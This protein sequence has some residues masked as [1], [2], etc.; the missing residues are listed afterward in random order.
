MSIG[1]CIAVFLSAVARPVTAW[2][3]GEDN[4]MT[5]SHRISRR[6]ALKAAA[7]TLALTAPPPARAEIK[8]LTVLAAKDIGPFRGKVYRE[9]EAQMKGS[10]PGGAYAVPVTLAFP[11]QASDHNGF[12]VVDVVNTIT[13]GKEQFVLGGRP[14]PLA[15][16]HM[17]DDF[18]F[19]TGN[20]YVSVIWDKKAVEALGNGTIATP[21]DGYTILRDAAALARNPAKT[22]A[23]G[24]GHRPDLRQDSGLRLLADGRLA[25][26][27]VFRSPEQPGRD[28]HLRRWPRRCRGWL[29]L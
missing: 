6:T 10:A 13:I 26:G 20:A 25:E 29:L 15:R 2:A 3:Q 19:G 22:S 8:D 4:A 11:K 9:V 23:R 28:A 24:R 12:A 18:L 17:G 1:R 27:L 7:I 5:D 16:M 21:A 14:L